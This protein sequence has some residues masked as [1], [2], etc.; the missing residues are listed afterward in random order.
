MVQLAGGVT[1]DQLR[2]MV[3]EE[4]AVAVSPVGAEGTAL[5]VSPGVVADSCAETGEVPSAST[6]A[7]V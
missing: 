1:A 7:T 2:P 5:H 3:L 6:A 4:E